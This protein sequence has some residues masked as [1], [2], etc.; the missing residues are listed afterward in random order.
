MYIKKLNGSKEFV[1]IH[2]GT[3]H[4]QCNVCQLIGSARVN[5]WNSPRSRTCCGGRFWKN[6]DRLLIVWNDMRSRCLD[7]KHPAY[8]RYNKFGEPKWSS[9]EDFCEWA[10]SSGWQY[11]LDIDRTNNA[12]GYFPENCK[13]VSRKVN[14][15][16]RKSNRLL[17]AFGETKTA[18]EWSEDNRCRVQGQ[19]ILARIDRY[20]FTVE[21]A[22]TRPPR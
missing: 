14:T 5:N 4:W 19:S 16:N 20:G 2:N 8:D 17:T 10:L 1:T 11:G 21:D 13:F 9:Y 22:I 18:V 7:P 12:L 15:R 6:R 3:V